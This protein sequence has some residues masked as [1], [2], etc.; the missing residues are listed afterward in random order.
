MNKRQSPLKNAMLTGLLTVSLAGF[1]APVFAETP[2]EE[3]GEYDQLCFAKYD[4]VDGEY[5][6]D[7]DCNGDVNIVGNEISGTWSSMFPIATVILK[8]GNDKVPTQYDPE[9]KSGSYENNDGDISHITFCYIK[10]LLATGV[11]L[12]A[13]VVGNKV[14]LELTTT[15][16]PDTAALAILRGNK[17]SNGGTEI[18]VACKFDSAGTTQNGATYKCKDAVVGDTYRVLETEYD[19]SVI[20]YDE[21]T[22]E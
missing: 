13:K 8:I 7:A 22:P 4:W 16:E 5:V 2:A 14:K 9:T 21:V 17:L 15:A 20:V 6:Q 3:C 11:N 18:D 19:G 12:T 10:P 1:T